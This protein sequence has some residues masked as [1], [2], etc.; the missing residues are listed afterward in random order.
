MPDYTFRPSGATCPECDAPVRVKILLTQSAQMTRPQERPK[1]FVCS[2]C[3]WETAEA[4]Y[5]D[6]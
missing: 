1:G 5:F 6:A 3:T 4:N 2:A